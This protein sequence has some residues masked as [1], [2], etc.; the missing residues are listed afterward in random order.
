MVDEIEAPE[1]ADLVITAS[2]KSDTL[3]GAPAFGVRQSS[4]ALLIS[5]A[6]GR[7]LTG[8]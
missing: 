1:I 4:G 8:L 2:R 7:P 5:A 3:E 6:L